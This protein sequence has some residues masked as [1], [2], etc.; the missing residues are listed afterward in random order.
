VA[1]PS[2]PTPGRWEV[3]ELNAWLVAVSHGGPA[4]S[5]VRAAGFLS[6][7]TVRKVLRVVSVVLVILVIAFTLV[8]VIGV[9][10]DPLTFTA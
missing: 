3:A 4:P 6:G 1:T 10:A 5:P 9:L 2:D 7:G 8:G